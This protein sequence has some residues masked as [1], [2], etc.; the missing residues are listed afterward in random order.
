MG[1]IFV[2]H[3]SIEQAQSY[4]TSVIERELKIY[5]IIVGPTNLDRS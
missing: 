4:L 2:V 5:D 1:D 3:P